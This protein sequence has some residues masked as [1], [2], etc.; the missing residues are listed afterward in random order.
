MHASLYFEDYEA[1]FTLE[2]LRRTVTEFD[3]MQ[4]VTLA[5][6]NEALFMDEPYI[7]EHTGFGRRIAPGALVFSLAEGLVIQTGILKDTAIAFLSSEMNM[8]GPVFVGDTLVNQAR[9][10][11]K[12]LASRGDRGVITTRH[13]VLQQDGK[14][15]LEYSA[16]R[17]IRCRTDS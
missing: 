7:R 3:I 17:L 1:D 13:S 14:P 12:K 2:T 5:G 9:F 10:E 8:K 4:F 11:S 6:M 15:V 16:S